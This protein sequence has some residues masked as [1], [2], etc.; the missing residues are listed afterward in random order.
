MSNRIRVFV[1]ADDAISHAG[2]AAQLRGRPEVEV[3]DDVDGAEAAVVSTARPDEQILSVVRGLRRGANL[4]VVLV[5]GSIDE[6]EAMLVIEA[7]VT[8]IVRR[9]SASPERLEAAVVATVRG[10][11][12]IPADLLGRVLNQVRRVQDEV[13]APRGFSFNGVSDREAYVLRLLADG[14]ATD[15]IAEKLCYSER[16]IKNVIHDITQRFGL[17]NRCHAVA[18]A[19]RQGLI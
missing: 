6:R 18:Y 8:A 4:P 2:V 19:V 3:V 17:C 15:A 1:A 5:T 9:S 11:G 10:E 12:A 7:G 14:L 13:L 16:T